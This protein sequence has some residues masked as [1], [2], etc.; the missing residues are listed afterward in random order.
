MIRARRSAFALGLE[1]RRVAI[2]FV[3][4]EPVALV[5]RIDWCHTASCDACATVRRSDSSPIALPAWNRSP[6]IAILL[7]AR[8]LTS[9]EVPGRIT[10]FRRHAILHRIH[11][12]LPFMTTSAA[13]GLTRTLSTSQSS[14]TCGRS[15]RLAI[16]SCSV[17][18]CFAGIRGSR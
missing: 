4:G 11:D 8:T 10:V 16:P 3:E 13:R 14:L 18:N 17:M 5:D 7:D 2:R 12:Q 15:R 6:P 9:S 1:L